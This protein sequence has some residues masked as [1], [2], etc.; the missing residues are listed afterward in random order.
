MDSRARLLFWDIASRPE[1][2]AKERHFIEI[3]IARGV[4]L[5]TFQVAH[6]FPQDHANSYCL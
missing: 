5:N 4:I 1:V 3:R 6:P 2:R